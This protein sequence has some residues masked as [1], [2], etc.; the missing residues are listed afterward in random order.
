MAAPESRPSG[1]PMDLLSKTHHIHGLGKAQYPE[2]FFRGC[3]IPP[4]PQYPRTFDVMIV[5]EAHN[6][7]PSGTGNYSLETLRTKLVRALAPHFEHRLFLTAT[8]ANGYLESFTSLLKILDDQRFARGVVPDRG[9]LQSIMVRRLKSEIVDKNGKKVFPERKL[10]R[11]EVNYSADEKE[12]HRTLQAYL[13]VRGKQ[14]DGDGREALGLVGKL[15]KKRL[16]SCPAAFATTLEAHIRGLREKAAG[17]RRPSIVEI[18][19]IER[20]LRD[21]REQ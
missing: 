15:L 13:K 3:V 20:G 4:I 16:F 9:Q 18:R 12:L 5:D 1:K 21:D 2:T 10:H 8:P 17:A 7:A 19:Q 11:L 6:V 14:S